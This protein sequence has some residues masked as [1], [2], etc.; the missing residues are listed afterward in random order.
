MMWAVPVAAMLLVASLVSACGTG[1]PTETQ[2]V[3]YSDAQISYRLTTE[4]SDAILARAREVFPELTF[5]LNYDAGRDD[6]WRDCSEVP[7]NAH[8]THVA[9]NSDRNV[10]I[11]PRQTTGEL[12]MSIMQIFID[13]GW[14]VNETELGRSMGFYGFSKDGFDVG[15][16]TA[17]EGSIEAGMVARL[18][19]GTGSPC[20]EAPDDLADFDPDNPDAYFGPGSAPTVGPFTPPPTLPPVWQQS[21]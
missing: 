13:D 15:F 9:W 12:V 2:E 16:Q 6:T 11:E 10:T 8:P 14:E 5:D 4:M 21:P 7:G 18:Y 3:R 17:T 1:Y 20:L 19:F